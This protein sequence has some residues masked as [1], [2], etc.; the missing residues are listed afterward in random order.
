[1]AQLS[2]RTDI[3]Y[4]ERRI[5]RRRR[6]TCGREGIG[7]FLSR[8]ISFLQPRLKVVSI[9][10]SLDNVD[11]IIRIATGLDSRS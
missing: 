1:M 7:Q 4:T 2:K 5:H 6:D 3:F 10:I 11:H 9:R 8:L